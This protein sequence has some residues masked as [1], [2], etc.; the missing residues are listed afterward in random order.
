MSKR[1]SNLGLAAR[2]ARAR[3]GGRRSQDRRETQTDQARANS[4]ASQISTVSA[5]VSAG[6]DIRAAQFFQQETEKLIRES[7]ALAAELKESSKRP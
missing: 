1:K 5:L 4:D 6:V 7:E 3:G 2:A